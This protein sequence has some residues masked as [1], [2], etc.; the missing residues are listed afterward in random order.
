MKK[1]NVELWDNRELGASEEHVG[2]VNL[3]LE[4]DESLG[5]QAISIRLQKDLLKNLKSIAS[6]Y[7]VGYQPMIRDLLN[8]FA[9]SEIKKI[10]RDQLRQIEKQHKSRSQDTTLPVDAF[11][12][13]MQKRA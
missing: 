9:E 11:I 8:R 13:D 6:Y 3:N 2:A 10:L 12:S 5:L 1:D 4:I 7:D